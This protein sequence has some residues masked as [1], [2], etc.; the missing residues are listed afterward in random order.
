MVERRHFGQSSPEAMV[1]QRWVYAASL[2]GV[3]LLPVPLHWLL[4]TTGAVTNPGGLAILGQLAAWMLVAGVTS[5]SFADRYDE[6]VY[7]VAILLYLIPY[8]MLSVPVDVFTRTRPH[9]HAAALTVVALGY[10]MLVWFAF[11][12]HGLPI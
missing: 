8:I 1:R 12:V 5:A 7:G 3:L 6:L 2:L 11:P 4:L 9:A 10:V